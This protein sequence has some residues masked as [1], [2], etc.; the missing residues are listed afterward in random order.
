[1]KKIILF[2]FAISI[3][4]GIKS[5]SLQ[6][7]EN[8]PIKENPQVKI[9]TPGVSQMSR[10][11]NISINEYLGIP[12][13]SIPLCNM[14]LPDINIPLSIS[15]QAT[16]IKVNQ[17][18]SSVGIGWDL[19]TLGSI[20]QIVRGDDDLKPYR[21]YAYKLLPDYYSSHYAHYEPMPESGYDTSYLMETEG[22]PIESVKEKYGYRMVFRDYFPING[23]LVMETQLRYS[24]T[25]WD[26][27]PDVFIINLLGE[28]LHC[29]TSDF[30]KAITKGGKAYSITVLNKTGYKVE[31][32]SAQDS[33]VV[34]NP[35]GIRFYFDQ[36]QTSIPNTYTNSNMYASTGSASDSSYDISHNIW[37]L[38]KIETALGT[39]VSLKYGSTEEVEF[40]TNGTG[41]IEYMTSHSQQNYD[42]VYPPFFTL[43]MFIGKAPVTHSTVTSKTKEKQYYLTEI[44]SKKCNIKLNYTNRED[45]SK[46][47]KLETITLSYNGEKEVKKVDFFYQYRNNTNDGKRLFLNSL[48]INDESYRFKYNSTRLP[49]RNSFAQDYWGYYNGNFNNNSLAPNPKRFGWTVLSSLVRYYDPLT[50]NLS[51]RLEYTKAGTLERISYPTG[52]SVEFEY[53]LNTFNNFWVP[54]YNNTNNPKNAQSEGFGLRIKTILHKDYDSKL[55]K[56]MGYEYYEGK[57]VNRHEFDK[58]GSISWMDD[59]WHRHSR[60]TGFRVMSTAS[61]SQVNPFS[62]HTGVGYDSVSCVYQSMTENKK[63]KTTTLYHNTPHFSSSSEPITRNLLHTIHMPSFENSAFPKNGLVKEKRYYNDSGDLNMKEEYQYENKKSAIFYGVKL[64]KIQN[65]HTLSGKVSNPYTIGASRYLLSYYPIFDFESL[66]TKKV[67]TN[68]LNDGIISSEQTYKYDEKRRLQEISTISSK[69]DHLSKRITYDNTW[70]SKNISSYIKEEQ[71]FLEEEQIMYRKLDYHSQ[72]PAIKQIAEG[73]VSTNPVKTTK[74]DYVS[75]RPKMTIINQDTTIYL[76]AFDGLYPIAEIKNS[77]LE[78]VERAVKSELEPQGSEMLFTSTGISKD[79]LK[80]FSNHPDLSNANVSTYTYKPLVG[81]LTAS[82]PSGTTI[83]YEYD[84]FGRLKNI[85]NTDQKL[86]N[87]YNYNLINYSIPLSLEV[88]VPA[89]IKVAGSK[90]FVA[91]VDGGSGMYEYNWYLKNNSGNI[92]KQELKSTDNEFTV[93]LS[94]IGNLILTCVVKDAITSSI[95][96][97]SKNFTVYDIIEFSSFNIGSSSD[98]FKDATAK[99]KC[100]APVRIKLKIEYGSNNNNRSNSVWIKIDS[101][102]IDDLIIDQNGTYTNTYNIPS[103]ETTISLLFERNDHSE[104]GLYTNI[105]IEE[106]V[107]KPSNIILGENNRFSVY[108]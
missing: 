34:I 23:R 33:W 80:Q 7:F 19:N 36:K 13:I 73:S 87:Q 84:N 86:V 82:D 44:S 59:L 49:S 98:T 75:S 65:V 76:W 61:L 40:I 69:G 18:A 14:E 77:T 66:M 38:T 32:M 28:K 71:L 48:K 9:E 57:S 63:F 39:V 89:S 83:D 88:P 52:G 100:S 106:V 31:R 85:K 46:Y 101:G 102:I 93:P 78:K 2:C 67:E 107:T 6:I 21:N 27:E 3:G 53:E 55:L 91:S 4:L 8:T 68:Y 15:Y 47:K 104:N 95:K 5:Q 35:Q 81:I 96:E 10:H 94:S 30:P 103:G 16:G 12:D 99:I 79:K 97:I 70:N 105:Y 58:Y 25:Y 11:D 51:A 108:F 90:T 74:I 22:Y 37:Y 56:K 72:I 60:T 42:P 62:T 20:V 17:D 41:T 43:Y 24:T 92:I 64:M 45:I 29:V 54:N 1:M 50:N 26:S